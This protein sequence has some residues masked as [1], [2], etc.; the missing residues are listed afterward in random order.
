[1]RCD[2]SAKDEVFKVEIEGDVRTRGLPTSVR[3]RTA[4]WLAGWPG[5]WVGGALIGPRSASQEA[6]VGY[7]GKMIWRHLE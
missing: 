3:G 2:D 1:M 6:P 5:W 4:G 7:D